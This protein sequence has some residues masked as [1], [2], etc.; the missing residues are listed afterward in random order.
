MYCCLTHKTLV[1][2]SIIIIFLATQ[3]C[4]HFREIYSTMESMIRV[5]K[6]SKEMNKI[7]FAN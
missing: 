1:H 3:S 4:R 6:E 5:H 2:P 7:A